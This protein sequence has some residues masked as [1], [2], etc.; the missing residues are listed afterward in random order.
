MSLSTRFYYCLIASGALS[1]LMV[2]A[3][4]GSPNAGTTYVGI[5]TLADSEQNRQSTAM[6]SL[7]FGNNWWAHVGAGK[8]RT[9][10]ATDSVNPTLAAIGFGVAG[11]HLMFT[12]DASSRNDGDRYQQRDWS[13]TLYWHS[14]KVG[15]GIDGMHRN[16]EV[17]GTVPVAV[18]QSNTVDVPVA[19]SLRGNGFGLHVNIDVT[20]RLNVFLGGMDY[21]YA[22]TTRQNG[23]V[24][25]SSGNP[26]LLNTVVNNLL[27]NQPLLAQQLWVQ[28]SGVTRDAAILQRSYKAGIGY[29]IARVALTAQ[30]FNDRALASDDIVNTAELSAAVSLG[31]HWVVV[32]AI[33]SSNSSQSSNVTFGALTVNYGW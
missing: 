13:S 25:A 16:T 22:T 24:A 29:R 27:N 30:Y 12:L 33:G 20:E 26:A 23:V 15:V 9:Q 5:S 14:E 18:S 11:Q 31:K 4:A 8:V 3:N 10:Q 6:L 17:R 1:L 19:Q 28:T 2:D 21:H 32:P 7:A